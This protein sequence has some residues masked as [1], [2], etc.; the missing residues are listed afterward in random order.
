MIKT[1]GVKSKKYINK[2]I[3][4]KKIQF[5]HGYSKNAK[6]VILSFLQENTVLF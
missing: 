5:Y 4:L 2:E 3:F 1:P 6:Y